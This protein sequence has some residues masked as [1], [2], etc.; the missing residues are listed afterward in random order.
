MEDPPISTK[1]IRMRVRTALVA[2]VL[3]ASLLP[4][5]AATA[6]DPLSVTI[7]GSLQSEAGCPGDWNPACAPTHL[8][9]DATDDVWQAAFNL[10]AANYEYKAALNDSWDENYGPHAEL[11]S[12]NNVPL[13]LTSAGSVKFYYDHKS[14]WVTD[15]R[16][17]VIAVAAGSFQSELG[18]GDWD[19]S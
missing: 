13:A 15:N 1:S 2:V 8:A 5:P 19:P 4:V 10:P 12:L 18:C 3:V 9:Y 6:A 7:A 14:H 17:S 11:N 16:S